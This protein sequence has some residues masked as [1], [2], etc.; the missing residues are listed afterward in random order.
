MADKKDTPEK[1]EIRRVD[2][3][4]DEQE[5]Q[6]ERSESEKL[7]DGLDI[8]PE[9]IINNPL[10]LLLSNFDNEYMKNERIGV[11]IFDFLQSSLVKYQ[12]MV[13]NNFYYQDMEIVQMINDLITRYNT[14]IA[15]QRGLILNTRDMV[16]EMKK[17]VEEEYITKK[18][19]DQFKEEVKLQIDADNKNVVEG[20]VGQMG[21]NLVIVLPKDSVYKKGQL[22]SIKKSRKA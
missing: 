12:R 21:D 20:V 22:V 1:D 19:L 13:N 18:A 3:V 4:L 16:K 7:F 6:L 17:M 9:S 5:L 15:N 2:F 11:V 14:W 10:A 8:T